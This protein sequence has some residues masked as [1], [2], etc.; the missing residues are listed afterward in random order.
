VLWAVAHNITKRSEPIFAGKVRQFVTSGTEEQ[1]L[2]SLAELE[3]AA[4]LASR[5]SPFAFEPSVKDVSDTANKPRNADY[6]VSLPS[7]EVHIEATTF[8]LREHSLTEDSLLKS[9]ENKLRDKRRQAFRERIYVL[10]ITLLGPPEILGI[11]AQLINRRVWPNRKQRRFAGIF[12]LV[13]DPDERGHFLASW[14]PNG[15]SQLPAGPDLNDVLTGRRCYHLTNLENLVV[16]EEMQRSFRESVNDANNN[17][18]LV[19]PVRLI[20]GPL[21]N[22]QVFLSAIK[23]GDLLLNYVWNHKGSIKNDSRNFDLPPHGPIHVVYKRKSDTVYEFSMYRL[24]INEIRP[25][26]NRKHEYRL[27]L[28]FQ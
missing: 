8:D 11:L 12:C 9:L 10:A 13:R 23:A 16:P 22:H 26:T 14:L 21:Q 4:L 5:V 28:T 7:G 25:T 27:R 17:N 15:L 6:S 3:T 19:I 20:G 18:G 2:F 24:W 1:Y